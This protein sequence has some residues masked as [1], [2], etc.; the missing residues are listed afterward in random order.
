MIHHLKLVSFYLSFFYRIQFARPW[1]RVKTL[2][3][4]LRPR[5]DS[6]ATTYRTNDCS[7][8][9]TESSRHCFRYQYWIFK[10]WGICATF[11]D[12]PELVSLT[13]HLA[14]VTLHKYNSNVLRKLGHGWLINQI[15]LRVSVSPGTINKLASV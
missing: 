12:N 6:N 11:N 3:V 14:V 15:Y 8:K 13:L 10:R 2:D 4:P 9:R 1:S 5:N 7:N